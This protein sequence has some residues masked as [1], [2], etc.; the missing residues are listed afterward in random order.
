MSYTELFTTVLIT[1]LPVI[2]W[3][4]FYYFKDSKDPE[5]K[6]IIFSLFL[7]GGASALPF[8]F[9]RVF[10]ASFHQILGGLLSVLVFALM[11]ELVKLA[12]ALLV[13]QK[14]KH[15]FNQV[16]D[17]VVYLAVTALGFAFVEN[18]VLFVE[19]PYELFSGAWLS[20]Y[21]FRSIGT[22][23][24]HTLFSSL[25]G[26]ILAYSVFSKKITPFHKEHLLAFKL[27][28]FLNLETLS[29]H[30]LRKNLL[31]AHPSRRGG[32]EK[33]VL[34]LEGV[35]FATLLHTL[36]NLIASNSY[37]STYLLVPLL[38]GG[39]AFIFYIYQL[40]F[41]RRIFKVV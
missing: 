30:I 36:Y 12:A 33:K 6:R 3:G 39:I 13:I 23:F 38:M 35:L 34:V 27:N 8:L 7:A 9:L 29:L 21:A 28:D 18:L 2:G 11:E 20:L 24:A 1:L 5:P 32:H 19:S 10:T 25:T 16:I 41:N 15:S 40:K 22:V 14:F 31:I 4:F 37:L 26:L 17:G